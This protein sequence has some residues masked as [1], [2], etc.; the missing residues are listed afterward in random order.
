M[1]I[2]LHSACALLAAASF[3][4]CKRS[5]EAAAPLRTPQSVEYRLINEGDTSLRT[6]TVSADMAFPGHEPLP[7]SFSQGAW[8]RDVRPNDTLVAKFPVSSTTPVPLDSLR[9]RLHLRVYYGHKVFSPFLF[10]RNFIVEGAPYAYG[11]T[12]QRSFRERGYD[13]VRNAGRLSRE[14]RWPSDTA[15]MEEVW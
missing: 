4:A 15:L 13:T 1:R 12:Y 14:I 11:W 6:I 8:F 3:A 10:A 9:R 5:S 2:H 7:G